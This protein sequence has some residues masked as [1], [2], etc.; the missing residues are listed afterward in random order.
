MC[1]GVGSRFWPFSKE[2]K[3]KQFLDFFGTGRSLL[4]STFDRF[5]KIVP[6]ENIYL[7]TNDAYAETIK[8]QLPEIND[9]QLLLEPIRR[10][11]APAI[12]YASFR[13]RAVN[14]NANIIVAPSDHL[15]VKE[16]QFVIDMKKGLE[17]V[18]HNPALLTL[19]IK[20]SRPETGYG[21]IQ[22]EEKDMDGIQKV[23][24]FTEKP[25]LDLARAFVE[26]GEFMW[27]SGIFLWN[28]KS[29]IDA[30][31]KHLPDILQKFSEG[32]S[33]F[34]TPAEK[35]FI[36]AS[37][38][39][40]PNISIDY[41][42]MEKADNVYVNISN[43]GWNDLGTWGALHDVSQ[44]DSDNN[45]Q[46]NCKTLYI[47]SN[48]NIVAMSDDKLVV[49]QGLEDYIVAESDNV[50]LICKKSEEQRIKHFVTDVKFRYGDEYV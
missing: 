14:P 3:P 33:L 2:D 23:K 9:N 12:A 11:T 13:I 20:P 27:N 47:E 34:N 22:V 44:R 7:V 50:L 30:F 31:Q 18:S 4:Q 45:A 42:I 38:P 40:C 1:G 17:F 25:N 37:F 6:V 5:K 41:G 32:E 8:L 39:F 16:D 29:I 35:Q 48:D 24:A 46:L 10:N 28:V 15:I 19:G 21:Y 49:L 36:D 43:F 26:S